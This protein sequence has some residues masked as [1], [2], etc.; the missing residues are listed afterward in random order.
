[1]K[2]NSLLAALRKHWLLTI[3]MVLLTSLGWMVVSAD[4]AFVADL[5]HWII[6]R[7]GVWILAAIF[8]MSVVVLWFHQALAHWLVTRTLPTIRVVGAHGKTL[9]ISLTEKKYPRE[10]Y[11]SGHTLDAH[12]ETHQL[13]IC[14]PADSSVVVGQQV[15]RSLNI[16]SSGD[17]I[18]EQF[19]RL[20]R[21]PPL[22]PSIE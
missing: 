14:Q 1:M 16:V 3:C 10:S 8:G 9:R 22:G 11:W 2:L 18:A 5:I 15:T 6:R 4:S 19:N 21:R 7:S 12:G 17:H 13:V 20:I